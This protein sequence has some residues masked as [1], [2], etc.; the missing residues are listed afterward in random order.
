[1]GLEEL[2]GFAVLWGEQLTR[3][4]R[5]PGTDH[6]P[7]STH[8]GTQGSGRAEYVGGEALVPE[9][10]HCLSVEECQGGKKGVGEGAPS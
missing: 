9:E 7:K 4:P 1:M 2:R 5:A 8:A 10:V 6:Q 3:S